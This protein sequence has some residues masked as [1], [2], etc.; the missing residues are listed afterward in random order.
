LIGGFKSKNENAYLSM[1]PSD[2]SGN[3]SHNESRQTYTT[4]TNDLLYKS[5]YPP[6]GP[7]HNTGSHILNIRPGATMSTL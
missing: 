4:T 1:N 6:T 5:S 2:I 7:G 3:P